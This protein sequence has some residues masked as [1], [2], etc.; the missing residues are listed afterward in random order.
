M[1][2]EQLAQLDA[3]FSAIDTLI[4]DFKLALPPIQGSHSSDPREMFVIHSL[5]HVATIQLHNPYADLETSR[6]RALDAAHAI[7][8]NLREIAVNDLVYIDP[9][10]GVCRYPHFSV[11]SSMICAVDSVHGHLSCLHG[12]GC[13]AQTTSTVRGPHFCCSASRRADPHGCVRHGSRRDEL[14]CGQLSAYGFD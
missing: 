13:A 6:V 3:S 9:I 4:E 14:V 7:V 8:G 12:R 11:P 2:R 1:T 5:A 10:M